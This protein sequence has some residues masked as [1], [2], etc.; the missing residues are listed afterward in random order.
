M[1]EIKSTMELVLER[2]ARMGKASSEEIANDEAKK[3]GMQLIAAYLEGK[4]DSPSQLLS[5]QDPQQQ[6]AVRRGMAE[7]LLRNIFLPR[8]EHARERTE[9]ATRGLLDLAGGAGDIVSICQEMQHVIGQ[10][11]QH[12]EQLKSRL[13]EQMRMQYEQLLA[14]QMGGQAEGMQI[15]PTTQPK[16]QEEWARV[17]AE[18]DDQYNQALA[19]YK[20]QLQQ[21]LAL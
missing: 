17:E 16:F 15:D 11:Q 6:Q 7:A 1:A 3:T 5:R 20:E 13:E 8:D 4:G 21:R 14:Q 12:R 18:L 10:Y 9:Q 19:Q 2:A